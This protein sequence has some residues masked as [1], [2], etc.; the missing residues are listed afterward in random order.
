MQKKRMNAWSMVAALCA[1]GLCPLFSIAAIFAGFRA[2]VEIKARGD[3]RGVRVAWASMLVGAT[4]TGL[5]VG[6]LL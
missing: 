4:I 1:I 5:W 2:L 6:G 3:T